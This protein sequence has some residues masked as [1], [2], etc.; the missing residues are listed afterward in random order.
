MRVHGVRVGYPTHG[1]EAAGRAALFGSA[2]AETLAVALVNYYGLR[3]QSEIA[4][5]PLLHTALVRWQ[6]CFAVRAPHA[7][8]R[9]PAAVIN[10]VYD[11]YLQTGSTAK[12]R[13]LE[14][15][16]AAADSICRQATDFDTAVQETQDAETAHLYAKNPVELTWLLRTLIHANSRARSMLR[17]S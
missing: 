7:R 8:P 16:L 9:S 2:R 10:I 3:A 12:T 4:T 11:R 15:A 1:C 6:R 5:A 13:R 17:Q 14:H